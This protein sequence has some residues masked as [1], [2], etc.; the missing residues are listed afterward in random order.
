MLYKATEL[1]PGDQV[2]AA[3]KDLSEGTMEHHAAGHQLYRFGG[4]FENGFRMRVLVIAAE[5]GPPAIC[6]SLRDKDDNEVR[7]ANCLPEP[8][9]QDYD[10]EYDS[11]VYRYTIERAAV[12]HLTDEMI[13][14][15][16]AA[17]GFCC[18][19]CGCDDMNQGRMQTHEGG[20]W[21]KVTC[22]SCDASWRDQYKLT[23]VES[24]DAPTMHVPPESET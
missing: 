17:G 5:S 23:A 6:I 1:V 18:P 2:N 16:V 7:S 9:D 10:F 11:H 8:L 12:V 21:C 24:I 3:N 4:P 22:C 20:A 19:H 13:A 15:Y 14:A